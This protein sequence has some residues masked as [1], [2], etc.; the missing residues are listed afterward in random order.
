MQSLGVRRL[1]VLDDQD[2]FEMPLADIVANYAEQ[3][4]ITVLAHDS[5]S[6]V[7][8]AVFTGEV[9]KIVESHAQAV[10]LAGGE[11]GGTAALWR[12]L[13]AAVTA[14]AAARLER[15]GRTNRSP[16]RSALPRERRI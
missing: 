4:G 11:G 5:L 15:D 9:E 12:D 8:G 2:P 13:H 7:A 3:A 6:T 10:F 1:Y 14:P 16:R